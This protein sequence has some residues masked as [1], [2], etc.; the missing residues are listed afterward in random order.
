M[1]KFKKVVFTFAIMLTFTTVMLAQFELKP[2]AGINFTSFSKDP[3][4]GS[5]SAQ[6]GWE[7]GG[8]ASFGDKLYFEGGIFWVSKSNQ[9]T[10][11]TVETNKIELDSE[12]GGVRIPVMAGYHLIGQE[13]SLIGLRGFAGASAFILNSVSVEGFSSD[14]FET[15]NYAV[16][17]GL[18]V[19]VT[20]FFVELMYEWSL[21]D[22][23]SV[24]S[25]DI[26]KARSIYIHAGARLFL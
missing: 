15:A 22:V 20:I 17:L 9:F 21:T 19:D 1:I 18:G 8:T 2:A 12:L 4:N 3:V 25:F 16:F 24:S 5:T 23:S 7:I 6:V 26:G 13:A 14:D 10:L 11:E